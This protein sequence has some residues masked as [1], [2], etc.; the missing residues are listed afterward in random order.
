MQKLLASF[1]LTTEQRAKYDAAR[2]ATSKEMRDIHEGKVSG[3]MKQDDV[4]KKALASPKTFNAA[5]KEILRAEQYAHW[6]PLRE[7]DHHKIVQAHQ[8][9]D[10]PAAKAG[11]AKKPEP[12][13]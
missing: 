9:R 13:N 7:A 5:V 4:L 1:D 11:A 2:A 3:T 10:E 8:Q 12:A 6:E